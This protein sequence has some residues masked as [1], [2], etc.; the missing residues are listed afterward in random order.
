MFGL[1]AIMGLATAFNILI[2][3]KK[4]EM[5]RHQDAFFDA[6]LLVI[7]TIV[8]GGS[9]GGMMVATVA[10]AI[11]SFYFLF[12]EPKLFPKSTTEKSTKSS[13][14]PKPTEDSLDSIFDLDTILA[15][16]NL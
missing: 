3:F 14:T 7:L 9:L 12:N 4:I 8:F 16:Y 15:Q 1:S 5:K 10:S 13:K 2:I 11:I 6:S